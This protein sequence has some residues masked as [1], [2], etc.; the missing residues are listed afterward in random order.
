[1]SR[2][3]ECPNL[4]VLDLGQ[5]TVEEIA[6]GRFEPLESVGDARQNVEI[7]AI[8]RISYVSAGDNRLNEREPS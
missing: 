7:A 8:S 4:A 3:H 5:E 6:E 2:S 1:M